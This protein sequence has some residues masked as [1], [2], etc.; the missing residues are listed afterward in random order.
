MRSIIIVLLWFIQMYDVLAQIEIQKG[1]NFYTQKQ[2]D[3][4]IYYYKKGYRTATLNRDLN[5]QKK[6]IPLIIQ[7]ETY[8]QNLDSALKYANL[9][10]FADFPLY[11]IYAAKESVFRKFL[12]YDSTAL[13]AARYMASVPQKDNITQIERLKNAVLAYYDAYYY[14]LALLYGKSLL[15]LCETEY[16]KESTE[17]AEIKLIIAAV[18]AKKGEISPT[19]TTIEQ[20]MRI[21]QKY[22]EKPE[23]MA[24]A[25]YAKS[26][27]LT[28]TG[29][30]TQAISAIQKAI[31]IYKKQLGE[32]S[33]PTAKAFLQLGILHEKT[34]HY[35]SALYYQQK[36]LVLFKSLLP[37]NDLY[38]ARALLSIGTTFY[39]QKNYD[40]AEEYYQNALFIQKQHYVQYHPQIAETYKY[41]GNV[42]EAKKDAVL[43]FRFYELAMNIY[44]RTLGKQHTELAQSYI[45]MGTAYFLKKDPKKSLEFYLKGIHI[46]EHNP[47]LAHH[48]YLL[49]GYEKLSVFYQTQK[50]YDKA[51]QYAEKAIF[52]TQ[53][54]VNSFNTHLSEQYLR[55]VALYHLANQYSNEVKAYQKAIDAL[56]IQPVS[57]PFATPVYKNVIV[58]EKAI[59]LLIQ[60]ANTIIE[61]YSYD[62]LQA[63]T[64]WA[65]EEKSIVPH[66]SRKEYE[67]NSALNALELVIEL[68]HKLF[69]QGKTI[70]IPAEIESKIIFLCLQLYQI[71]QQRHYAEKLLSYLEIFSYQ[72][73]QYALKMSDFTKNL[74]LSTK[75]TLIER[76]YTLQKQLS[77]LKKQLLNAC[78]D[79]YK[80]DTQ[81][82]KILLKQYYTAQQREQ[83]I[84]SDIENYVPQY[85]EKY[86]IPKLK[87]TLRTE[88]STDKFITF[89]PLNALSK[90]WKTVKNEQNPLY[91]AKAVYYIPLINGNST[92]ILAD[93]EKIE[94]IPLATTL[95]TFQQITALDSA[96]K[97]QNLSNA[98]QLSTELYSL[99]LEP[100]KP[101]LDK[102]T[103]IVFTY[104]I[105]DKLSVESL[106]IDKKTTLIAKYRVFYAYSLIHLL[107]QAVEKPKTT[108]NSNGYWT[109]QA[110]NALN[111]I[112]YHFTPYTS[113]DVKNIDIFHTDYLIEHQKTLLSSEVYLYILTSYG[114]YMPYPVSNCIILRYPMNIETEQ[115]F[116]ETFYETLM[117]NNTVWNAFYIAEQRV[118]KKD[119][120]YPVCM[121]LYLC[122]I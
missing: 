107:N 99:L 117:K 35:D 85:S 16:T 37:E 9:M 41:L 51:I 116:W 88:T 70:P 103:L 1:N 114:L 120:N 7:A 79:G 110:I 113:F 69:R 42:M 93:E 47:E 40:K 6:Y 57:E 48:E 89:L 82:V 62:P 30:Y 100:L 119:R 109:K 39:A 15:S 4:A 94:C 54:K 97:Q 14:D 32:S 43:C 77:D 2:Y 121:R 11:E 20:A 8:A 91:K 55:L 50:E 115:Q 18:L 67:L 73:Y 96:L 101:Y 33:L 108:F 24:Y 65:E 87:N 38:I 98:T 52:I 81:Q 74:H 60:K 111:N 3:S 58:E 66:E 45:N 71:S 10:Y 76:Y 53:N 27:A 63:F 19:Q 36:A 95:Q 49:N 5:T 64:L 84:W 23:L 26:I 21:Y 31:F 104:G 102:N 44:T 56:C 22:P 13:Y 68:K 78:I 28:Q 90:I 92:V 75:D 12:Y 105:F 34:A 122:K 112:N 25:Q 86:T 61:H 17:Y 72:K 29:K 46:L 106:M 118:L 59:P 80:T 83:K